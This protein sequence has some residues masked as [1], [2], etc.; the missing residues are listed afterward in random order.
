MV[1]LV[2][3][4]VSYFSC[5]DDATTKYPIS[6]REVQVSTLKVQGRKV[7]VLPVGWWNKVFWGW[8]LVWV[9]SSWSTYD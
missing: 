7:G 6:T 4:M 1:F 2:Y 9:L 8:T 5:Y 3:F